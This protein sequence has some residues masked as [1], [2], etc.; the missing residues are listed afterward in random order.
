[1]SAGLLIHSFIELLKVP[2]GF[3]PRNVLFVRTAFN[4]ARYPESNKRREAERLIL[5]KL[6]VLPNV[7]EASLTSHI[8][9]ADERQ[10]GFVVEGRSLTDYHWAHNALVSGDYFSL[11]RIP[12]KRGR[13]F[14]ERDTPDHPL[15]IV[16][17]E[18]MA[19]RYWPHEDAIGKRIF[20]GGRKVTVVGI[21]GDVRLQALDIAPEPTIYGDVFQ[22]ESGA[23]TS[24]VFLLRTKLNERAAAAQAQKIIWS[25]DGGL[26]VFGS[27]SM[28]DVVSRSLATRRFLT[29]LL[30]SF[31]SI[32]LL[33]ATIGLYGVLAYTVQQ[34]TQELGIRLALGAKPSQVTR[35][36]LNGG[37]KRTVT[38]FLLGLLVSRGAGRMV[39]ALLFGIKPLDPW[40]FIPA[41]LLLFC[42]TLLASYRPA[43][44]AA[45]VD[46]MTALR[47]E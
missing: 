32:A 28:R 16:I 8:P 18:T 39:S 2:P 44:R 23:S 24:A 7:E 25:V 13:T 11:M 14:D 29:V 22:A 4:R 41:A 46:P 43:K 3:D 1:V 40:A 35:L 27:R 6:R 26:P 20:W 31:A 38:G 17:S 5:A 21:V 42:V 19:R 37:A 30:T 33:L 34:R 45:Q 10:I 12:I 9:L 47:F 15:S 36:I